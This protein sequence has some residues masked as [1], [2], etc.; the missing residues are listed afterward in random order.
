MNFDGGDIFDAT[1]RVYSEITGV[2]DS[3][4]GVNLS[5]LA[6]ITQLILLHLQL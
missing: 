4:V 3:G 1:S 5:S 2:T 6:A